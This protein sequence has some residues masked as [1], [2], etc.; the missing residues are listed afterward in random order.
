MRADRSLPFA[1]GLSALALALAALPG[2]AAA[3]SFSVS[4][5]ETRLLSLAGSASD[6]LVGDPAVADVTVIDH[7]H[8]LIHGKSFGRT[9]LVVMD[10]VG[11]TL[12]SQAVIV[13]AGDEGRVSVFRGSAPSEYT[14]AARCE[15][16]GGKEAGSAGA[17]AGA[18][19]P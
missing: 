6:V 12:F 8:I 19:S 16:V 5:G 18:P 17:P 10:G 15:Q 9:N 13:S 3:Q 2:V 1:A 7:G 14:C 4:K 11:R